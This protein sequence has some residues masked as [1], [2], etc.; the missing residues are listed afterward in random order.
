M[1]FQLYRTPKLLDYLHIC[2]HMEID[3]REQIEAFTGQ[4]YDVE[5]AAMGFASLAGPAWLMC[6]DEKPIGAAG[7]T[8]IR[9]GVWQDW[10][11]TTPR[12]WEPDVWRTTTKH[13]KRVM[14]AMLK[15]EAHRLQCVSLASRIHAHKWYRVIGLELEGPLRAY[16]AGGEDA[17]MFARVRKD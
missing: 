1:S 8:M 10:M 13:V 11:A 4:P 15:T 2:H 16:G 17:L 12:C 14:D 3:Q 9:R 6:E 5:T 7:F